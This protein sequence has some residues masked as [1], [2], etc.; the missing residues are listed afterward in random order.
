MRKNGLI[1]FLDV[2][3]EE[4]YRRLS[5]TKERPLLNTAN[6]LNSIK[7]LLEK[8][9]PY[10]QRADLTVNT[11]GLT[12]IETAKKIIDAIKGWENEKKE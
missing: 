5:G 6:P 2:S 11:S 3:A 7:E 12:I 8:R 1:V 10:Y 9:G 4:V